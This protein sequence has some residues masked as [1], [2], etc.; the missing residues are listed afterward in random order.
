M[1]CAECIGATWVRDATLGPSLKDDIE[2]E[3]MLGREIWGGFR[4]L[5]YIVCPLI[6][7]VLFLSG[8]VSE[9]FGLGDDME[10][11]ADNPAW[12]VFLLFFYRFSIVFRL[13]FD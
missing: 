8:M 6:C 4:L 2:N 1:A 13:I 12:C 7:G 5:W 9:I 11:M 3:D 10:R